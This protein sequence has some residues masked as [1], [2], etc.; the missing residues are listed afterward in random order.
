TELGSGAQ[1]RYSSEIIA[2]ANTEEILY[3]ISFTCLMLVITVARPQWPRTIVVLR[4]AD[5]LCCTYVE[6]PT[7]IRRPAIRSGSDARIEYGS[8]T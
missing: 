3:E 8:D 1:H 7:R 4:S 5:H 6:I 2:T